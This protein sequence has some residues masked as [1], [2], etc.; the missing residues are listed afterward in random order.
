MKRTENMTDLA[1]FAAVFEDAAAWAPDLRPSLSRD[2]LRLCSIVTT[3]GMPFVY[4]DMPEA[5]KIF[6]LSLSRGRFDRACLPSTFGK[7]TKDDH[8]YFL[9]CLFEKV[10]TSEGTLREQ[11]DE[12]AIFFLRQV[13]YF[14]KKVDVPCPEEA[15]RRAVDEFIR[16]ESRMRIPTCSWDLDTLECRT[17]TV[18]FLDGYISKPDLVSHRDSVPRP[19][20]VT[21]QTVSDIVTSTMPEFDWRTIVPGHGPGAVSDV[22]TGTDKYQ[23]K[24]WPRKLGLIFPAEYFAQHREDLHPGGSPLVNN[25]SFAKLAAVPKTYKGPRLITVEPVAHQYVQQGMLRWLRKNFPRPLRYCVDFRNQNLSATAALQSSLDGK[26][27]TIDLSSA[28]DRLSCWVIERMFRK[29][30]S[31]L[32]ALHACRTRAVK[33]TGYDDLKFVQMRKYAGQGNAT[34][35]P[36]Q[37]IAYSIIAI[38]CIAFEQ[39]T[40]LSNSNIANLAKQIRVFG[41]DIIMPSF[42]VRSLMLLLSHLGLKVNMAK[43]HIEGKFRESCGTDAYNGVDVTPVY[44]RSFT[45][46]K[47]LSDLVSWIDVSNNAY[48]SGL[49]ALADWMVGQIPARHLNLIPISKGQLG[50]LTLHANQDCL[51]S[52]STRYNIHLCRDEIL[53]LQVTGKAVR[54]RRGENEGLLQYF[55]EAP[56]PDSSGVLPDWAA[57]YLVRNRVLVRARWVPKY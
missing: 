46:G 41:D 44:I 6:D 17:Q 30:P 31:L 14:G 3:R 16:I 26:S 49:W 22:K 7:V 10:F 37:S 53:A 56:S 18:S 9:K 19:L 29:N 4:L 47:R 48:R 51:V 21:L 52:S 33:I 42:A 23:F 36:V 2:Y 32:S 55:L 1:P 57:G 28:S 5:G 24:F 34:T 11:V 27:A 20:L 43:S 12:N 45:L 35:F 40:K 39:S 54:Q 25:E 8:K 15:T 50:C 13:L 38:A